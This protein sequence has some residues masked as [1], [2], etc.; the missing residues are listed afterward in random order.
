M[1]FFLHANC[2]LLYSYIV[3]LLL[4]RPILLPLMEEQLVNYFLRSEAMLRDSETGHKTKSGQYR[5][6][7]ICV[8]YSTN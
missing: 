6:W 5:T 8:L 3:S 1:I 7:L 2:H 4:L